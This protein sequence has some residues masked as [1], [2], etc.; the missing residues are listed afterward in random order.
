[1]AARQ[2]V[3]Q[4]HEQT[5]PLH[6]AASSMPRARAAGSFPL[7]GRSGPYRSRLL[8]GRDGEENG[9]LRPVEEM[10]PASLT[11]WESLAITPI[12]VNLVTH[13]I[14]SMPTTRAH[15]RPWPPENR[16]GVRALRNCKSSHRPGDGHL[17]RSLL[18]LLVVGL[19]RRPGD[20]RWPEKPHRPCPRALRRTLAVRRRYEVQ[21]QARD[22]DRVSVSWRWPGALVAA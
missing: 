12:G 22:S 21:H 6:R 7:R 13:G 5:A 1:M 8:P 10:A 17:L 3:D 16:S 19:T 14:G 9:S 18:R 2:P 4:V 11:S 20:T 15:T